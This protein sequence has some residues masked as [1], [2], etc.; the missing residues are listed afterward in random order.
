MSDQW[1]QVICKETERYKWHRPWNMEFGLM[2]DSDERC[3]PIIQIGSTCFELGGIGVCANPK[4][5]K[6]KFG[7]VSITYEDKKLPFHRFLIDIHL[8]SSTDTTDDVK[9]HLQEAYANIKVNNDIQRINIVTYEEFMEREKAQA[10]GEERGFED[11]LY[12]FAIIKQQKNIDAFNYFAQIKG[13][14]PFNLAQRSPQKSIT[15]QF[16]I[17]QTP[18]VKKEVIIDGDGFMTAAKDGRP[19]KRAIPHKL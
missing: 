8:V 5:E 17:T 1:E 15:K 16:L 18:K 12:K 6:R 11:G 19:K 2:A 3:D 9:K 7:N 13:K 10:N 4:L 14:P